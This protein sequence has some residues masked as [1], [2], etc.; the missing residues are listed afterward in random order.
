MFN[1]SV[2]QYM[3]VATIMVLTRL[4][5][6]FGILQDFTRFHKTVQGFTWLYKILQDDYVKDLCRQN[7]ISIVH[8]IHGYDGFPVTN[9]SA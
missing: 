8:F 7:T 9:P 6:P 2:L 3:F 4:S 5:C 1:C